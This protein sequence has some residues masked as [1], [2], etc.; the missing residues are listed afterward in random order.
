MSIKSPLEIAIYELLASI[1]DA[2]NGASAWL[3]YGPYQLILSKAEE[4]R[5]IA[6]KNRA[7]DLRERGLP[8]LAD[9][10]EMNNQL[11]EKEVCTCNKLGMCPIHEF[12][13]EEL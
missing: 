2:S 10:V 6:Y 1:E 12:S 11:R 13:D 5:K 7:S 8:R 3:D 4:L 9:A